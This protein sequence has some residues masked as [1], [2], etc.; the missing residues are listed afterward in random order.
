K[1]DSIGWCYL[2]SNGSMTKNEWVPDG[3]KWYYCDANGYMVTGTKVIGGKTYK[4]DA[5]GVWVG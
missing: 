5:N 1:K 4:F 3:G 2:N